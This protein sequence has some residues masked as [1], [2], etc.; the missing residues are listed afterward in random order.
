MQWI[1]NAYLLLLG[2]LVLAG[3]AV[4]DR[5]GRRRIFLAGIAVF[6]FASILCAL[7]P[8]GRADGALFLILARALHGLGAAMLVP[9]SLAILGSTFGENER[10]AAGGAWA[11]FGALTTAAGPVLG[12]WLVDAVSWRAIFLLNVPLAAIAVWLTLAAEPESRDD[13]A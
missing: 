10:G 1:L 6:T 7:T 9:G 11:G 4:G 12:G 5:Y 8:A 13:D 3:G 2:A